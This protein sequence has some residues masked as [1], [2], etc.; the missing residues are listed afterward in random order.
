VRANDLRGNQDHQPHEKDGT[1]IEREADEEERAA[2]MDRAPCVLAGAEQRC[3]VCR[4]VLP[5]RPRF[6]LPDLPGADGGTREVPPILVST[7]PPASPGEDASRQQKPRFKIR[8]FLPLH[9]NHGDG[10]GE[11]AQ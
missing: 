8:I 3:N 4:R 11:H 9:G 7:F 10:N 1:E 5:R 2:H 6:V